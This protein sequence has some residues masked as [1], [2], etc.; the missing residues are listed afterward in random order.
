[1][2]TETLF[3][4]DG[5][6]KVDVCIIVLTHNNSSMTKMFLKKM[7]QS[8][9]MDKIALIILD[10]GSS[11]D[12][13]EYLRSVHDNIENMVLGFSDSNMG[14]IEGRNAG[15][16]LADDSFEFKYVMFLDNDQLVSKGWIDG[17]LDTISSYDAV[18]VEAWSMSPSFRPIRNITKIGDRYVYIGAGGMMV[19]KQ[20]IDEIGLF[21]KRY[22]PMYFEDPDF[23]FSL[24]KN[25]YSYT[26]IRDPKIKHLGHKTIGQFSI[27]KRRLNFQTSHKKFCEKWSN[28]NLPNY[29]L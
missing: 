24:L 27:D 14:V 15:Y 6:K 3:H 2:I 26:C 23:C 9:D 10:N 8:T 29:K 12:T 1:M 20:V 19:K 18:G 22:S 28:F 11:D 17:Y 7:F 25:G 5:K 13:V 16:K 4:S 21:D